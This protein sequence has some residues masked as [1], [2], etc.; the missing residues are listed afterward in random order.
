MALT[1]R[2]TNKS[3]S[4]QRHHQLNTKSWATACENHELCPCQE[5]LPIASKL[6]NIKSA[7]IFKSY[8]QRPFFF[9]KFKMQYG[10]RMVA[11]LF[12]QTVR[13]SSEYS[14]YGW[15]IP[16]RTNVSWGHCHFYNFKTHFF[17]L[18]HSWAYFLFVCEISWSVFWSNM[19]W[20]KWK[21]ALTMFSSGSTLRT[22]F[23]KHLLRLGPTPP[24]TYISIKQLHDVV[25]K[26]NL[27][28]ET[29][30]NLFNSHLMW[31]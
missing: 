15:S 30:G 23:C 25:E 20:K 8:V 16:H 13:R 14:C 1:L 7:F 5:Q 29:G 22:P 21:P 24:S 18:K 6:R 31:I 2:H 12:P 19:E 28:W 27:V 26:P 3:K 4:T 17:P 11:Y 10:K 9:T